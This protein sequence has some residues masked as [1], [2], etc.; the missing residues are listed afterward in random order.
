MVASSKTRTSFLLERGIHKKFKVAVAQMDPPIT[1]SQ[2]LEFL[3]ADFLR[4]RPPIARRP[5]TETGHTL[6]DGLKVP[7]PFALPRELH[8]TLKAASIEMDISMGTIVES[9]VY[10][11]LRKESSVARLLRNSK[12]VMENSVGPD[13]TINDSMRSKTSPLGPLGIEGITE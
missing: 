12:L 8:K 11:F 3:L 7:V 2:V 4:N 1:K 6:E 13:N 9:L 10:S 5:S